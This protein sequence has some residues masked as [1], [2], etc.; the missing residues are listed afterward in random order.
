M[1]YADAAD[2]REAFSPVVQA[3]LLEGELEAVLIV[4]ERPPAEGERTLRGYPVVT[5]VTLADAGRRA[6]LLEEVYHGVLDRASPARCFSPHH[7][8]AAEHDGHR[9]EVVICFK[10]SQLEVWLDGAK[11]GQATTGPRASRAFE[12]LLGPIRDPLGAVR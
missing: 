1:P 11:A 4:C 9:A 12:A 2:V 10:C 3:A 6:A 5:S 7:A 8:L